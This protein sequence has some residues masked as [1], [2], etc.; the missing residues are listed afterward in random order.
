[1]WLKNGQKSNNRQSESPT[2]FQ[3]RHSFH[4]YPATKMAERTVNLKANLMFLKG[5]ISINIH[6]CDASQ[7][8]F[9]E[10]DPL[11]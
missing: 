11:S 5:H 4:A 9:N 3:F 6:E 10:G 2:Q 8:G 1:M 7:K